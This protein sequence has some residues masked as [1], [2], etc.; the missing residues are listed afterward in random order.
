MAKTKYNR[1]T[2]IEAIRGE[3]RWAGKDGKRNSTFGNI[4]NIAIRL[5]VTR[6][7]VYSYMDRWAT[8]KQ[9]VED[10]KD[11]MLD[12]AESKLFTLINSGNVTAI[13]FTL[14]TQGKGRGWVERTELAGV[15]DR[16][17][18]INVKYKDG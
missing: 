12:F 1:E 5:G 15:E 17:I 2:V 11:E 16:D 9:A 10:A 14:K 8:V 4:T 18:N 3:G 7:T 6:Q 13:I